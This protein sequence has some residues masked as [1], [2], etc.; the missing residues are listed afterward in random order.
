MLTP[1]APFP[2]RALGML[3]GLLSFEFSFILS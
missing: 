1:Q 2:L 3:Y